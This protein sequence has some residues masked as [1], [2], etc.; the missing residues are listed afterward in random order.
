MKILLAAD[1]A[2][3]ELKNK[4]KD[5]LISENFDVE[6]MGWRQGGLFKNNNL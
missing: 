1:H 6:D 5:F 2:G 3:F 4:I